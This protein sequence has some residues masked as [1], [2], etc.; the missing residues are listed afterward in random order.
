MCD[1]FL[2]GGT[3]A[4]SQLLSQQM[5][6]RETN[7]ASEAN[8]RTLIA[9]ASG[10]QS[11]LLIKNAMVAGDQARE[12]YARSIQ[13]EKALAHVNVAFSDIYGLH[14]AARRDVKNQAMDAEYALAQASEVRAVKTQEDMHAIHLNT[15]AGLSSLPTVGTGE[16]IAG[17]V[18]AGVTGAA[19]AYKTDLVL[20]A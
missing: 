16:Q 1:P 8:A 13:E 10:Q 7:K 9:Q 20:K 2:I 12:A 18:S 19:Y 11:G 5:S 14:D 4:G 3:I 6:A 15:L 17:A